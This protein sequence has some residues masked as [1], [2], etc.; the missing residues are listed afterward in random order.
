MAWTPIFLDG[1]LAES[2]VQRAMMGACPSR[3]WLA[4]VAIPATRDAD[5]WLLVG[6]AVEPEEPWPGQVEYV[7]V[8]EPADPLVHPGE[9]QGSVSYR[10]ADYAQSHGT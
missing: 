7:L 9:D 4:P 6:A 1:P 8:G 3:L 5:G 2:R 10:M